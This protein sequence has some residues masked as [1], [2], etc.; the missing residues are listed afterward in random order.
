MNLCLS[1]SGSWRVS[2]YFLL[3]LIIGLMTGLASGQDGTVKWT[4]NTGSNL[5]APPAIG[6]DG[7]IYAI[8]FSG[9]LFAIQPDGTEKWRFEIEAGV[10]QPPVVA[11][12]GTVYVGNQAGKVY[13]VNPDGTQK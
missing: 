8:P 10:L 12:D 7:T 5:T 9:T 6:D 11:A 13:A 4:F 2:H 1:Q 3:L